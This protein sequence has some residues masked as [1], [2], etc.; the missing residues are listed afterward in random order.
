MNVRG[1]IMLTLI[2]VEGISLAFSALV[3]LNMLGNLRTYRRLGEYAA[4]ARTEAGSF[5]SVLVPARDEA[6]NIAACLRSLL[7]QDY[8]AFEVRV[9][10]DGSTDETAAI[11]RALAAGDDRLTL[12]TGQP[13]L[14]GWAGKGFACHQLAGAARGD[15]LLFTDA[16]TRH[17]PEMIRAVAGAVAGGADVVTTFPEQEIGGWAEALA[18]PMMLFTVWAFLPV[19]RVWSDPSPQFTAAN[20]QLLAFTRAA[21]MTVGGHAAVR[22]SVLEDMGLAQRA[23]RLGL[24]LRLADGTGTTRTRMYRSSGEVWRGFSKNAYA[25]LGGS[26]RLAVAFTVLLLALYVVPVVVLVTGIIGGVGWGR[27]WLPLMLIALMLVQR[28]ILAWRAHLPMWQAVLHPFSVLAFV[29]I[30]AN[31]VRWQ[32]RGYGVWKGRVYATTPALPPDAPS[33]TAAP[34]R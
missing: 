23:K 13:L 15:I 10:D 7:A 27:Q 34:P 4:L 14:P 11:V 21:Y 2:I 30:L 20:G 16:D 22:D 24:K 28:G 17:A 25:L 19:G 29:L 31:S 32:Q 18:V 1:T 3:T 5:V 33:G 9:L 26:A 6:A 8:P 12:L